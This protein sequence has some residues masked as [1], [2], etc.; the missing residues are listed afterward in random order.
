MGR[1]RSGGRKRKWVVA[2][3]LEGVSF[4]YEGRRGVPPSVILGREED[5]PIQEGVGGIVLFLY[6]FHKGRGDSALKRTR[7]FTWKGKKGPCQCHCYR[8]RKGDLEEQILRG[9]RP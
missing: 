8:E 7:F 9:G 4:H 1:A 5:F 3:G 6:F 2:G